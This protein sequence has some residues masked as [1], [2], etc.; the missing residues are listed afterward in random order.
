MNDG[1]DP[2]TEDSLPAAA[3][4]EDDRAAAAGLTIAAT[5][6]ARVSPVMLARMLVGAG[7]SI[8][9]EDELLSVLQRVVGIAHDVIAGADSTG[10][11]I[12]LAGRTFTAVHTDHRTLRVDSEQYDAGEGPCLHAARTRSIVLVDAVDAV[13]TW[14]RFASAA[15]EE[16]IRSF[17][18]APLFTP[19]GTLGSLNLYGRNQSA[20]DDIDAE[21]LDL[22][23]TAV[24]RA[25]GD[26]ARFKS[27]RDVAESIQRAL[28]HRAPIEQAKGMLM[29]IHGIDADEAFDLLRKQSQEMNVRLRTVA[30]NFVEQLSAPAAPSATADPQS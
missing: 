19:E 26:F 25:V 20:F 3:A 24:S 28:E 22:L 23:T 14:P 5:A 11:T 2:R 18:A 9:D 4:P 6:D 29:A 16:G 7:D 8:D 10:V 12:D 21:I 30:A 1:G 27:Q 15:A 13:E 17:L